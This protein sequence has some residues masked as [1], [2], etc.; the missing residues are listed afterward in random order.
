M[1]I[2]FESQTIHI[3]GE[4]GV[5]RAVLWVNGSSFNGAVVKVDIVLLG[6]GASAFS[7]SAQSQWMPKSGLNKPRAVRCQPYIVVEMLDC[8]SGRDTGLSSTVW[9]RP[10]VCAAMVVEQE[11]NLVRGSSRYT[12]LVRPDVVRVLDE[13]GPHLIR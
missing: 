2:W 3:L 11:L 12:V 4:C 1:S 7:P 6:H 8:S 10:L 5:E 9:L 13:T